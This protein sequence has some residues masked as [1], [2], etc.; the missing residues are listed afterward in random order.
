MSHLT[1]AEAECAVKKRKTR[2]ELFLEKLE[3]LLPWK[4]L[5]ARIAKHYARGEMGRPSYPL[6]AMLRVHIMQ[7]VY[8]LSDPAMEDTPYEIESMRRFAGIRLDR[9][10]D[11]TTI[12][13]F[14]HLLE[15]HKL[16]KKLFHTI[17]SHLDRHGL[18][19]REGSIVDASIIAAPGSTKNK[20]GKRDPEMHQVKKGN[21]WHCGVKMHI[22]VDES[23][24]LIHSLE[25]T[26]ANEHDL[27][28]ADK[29]LHG[30]ETR[31]W[32]DAG[33]TGA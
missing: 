2:R 3:A 8:N 12:L 22:G 23:L 24:G 31:V 15:R 9:V 18:V 4:Q 26:P 16:G 32:A 21:E 25:T 14:R 27:N 5:E 13:D 10:P 1:F 19:L 17:N 30:Q 33:Y 6:P 20:D 11:E 29:L 7:L 28:V